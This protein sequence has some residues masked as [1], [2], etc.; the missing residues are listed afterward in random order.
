MKKQALIYFGLLAGLINILFWF[1][2]RSLFQSQES[3]F[4]VGEILGYAAMLLA[5]STVFFGVKRYRDTTLGGK[6]SFVQAF[7]NGLIVVLVAAAIYVIGWEI[8]YPNFASDFSQEYSD[9]LI[10]KYESQGLSEAEIL[11]KKEEMATWMERYE[12]PFYR[13]PM[14]LMEILPLGMVI[15]VVSALILKRK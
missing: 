12:S 10:T 2:F 8:Y 15:S 14:T 9:Y 4:N 11:T 13:I 5:L 3:D 7:V 1:L 6:I